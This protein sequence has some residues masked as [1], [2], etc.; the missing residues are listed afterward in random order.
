MKMSKN[1]GPKDSASNRHKVDNNQ[2]R[3]VQ[4]DHSGSEPYYSVPVLQNVISPAPGFTSRLYS[5]QVM[6]QSEM[7]SMDQYMRHQSSICESSQCEAAK[8]EN[9]F[10]SPCDSTSNVQN[11]FSNEH[12]SSDKPVNLAYKSKKKQ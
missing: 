9:D 8:T 4:T 1:D 2:S 6:S 7:E 3:S 12:S 5:V 10:N 11:N